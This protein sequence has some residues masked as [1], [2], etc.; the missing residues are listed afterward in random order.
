M[1]VIELQHLQQNTTRR[2]VVIVALDKIMWFKSAYVHD[3]YDSEN[4]KFC[5]MNIYF[6]YIC[7]LGHYLLN[8]S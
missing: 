4:N 1:E 5:A 7:H 2:V 3:G 6:L 8:F